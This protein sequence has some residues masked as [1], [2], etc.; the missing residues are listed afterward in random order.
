MPLSPGDKLGPYE[1]L[2]PIG[3]GGIQP[4]TR[5]TSVIV[6]SMTRQKRR[7]C[8]R[9]KAN[10][11]IHIIHTTGAMPCRARRLFF[12]EDPNTVWY[13]ISIWLTFPRPYQA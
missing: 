1:I 3:A 5:T 13:F 11:E 2:S 7:L 4:L 10:I 8:R 6:G 9:G 12:T